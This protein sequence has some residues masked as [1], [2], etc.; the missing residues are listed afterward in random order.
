MKTL[1]RVNYISQPEPGSVH[2]ENAVNNIQQFYEEVMAGLSKVPKRL[3]SK[4]FYDAVGDRL[5]QQ[6]MHSQDYYLTRCELEIFT[7][8]LTEMTQLLMKDGTAFDLIELGPG[9]GYK[10][11][12][13]LKALTKQQ[14]VFNYIP[15]DISGAVLN[16]LKTTLPALLPNLSLQ[17]MN[18]EYFQMLS[19]AYRYSSNRKVVLCLGANIGNM[20]IEESHSFCK[21][22]RAHLQPGDLLLVG[23]DLVKN[24]NII[25]RA[26]ND[27]EGITSKFNLNL[28]ERINKELGANFNLHE[29]EHYCSYEPETGTCKSFLISL[30][31]ST[32][33]I[34]DTE[35]SFK[36]DEYIW[37]EISQK[38]TLQQIDDMAVRTGFKPIARLMD[39]QQWFTDACWEVI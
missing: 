33:S 2:K 34:R 26:Y 27:R 32:V 18:G 12:H 31:N 7:T 21:T 37:M 25:R 8:R 28:L 36:K 5:F 6:I 14:A 23:F 10:S 22:L 39:S 9:D 11:V 4:Y 35:V 24:P 20:S 29:F 17:P 3:P 1:K 38:F 16:Q 19:Q 30:A 15:I 13:L